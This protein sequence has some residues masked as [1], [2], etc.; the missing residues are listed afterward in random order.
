M[1]HYKTENGGK[2]IVFSS[3]LTSNFNTSTFILAPRWMLPSNVYVSQFRIKSTNS[4][5]IPT[6]LLVRNPQSDMTNVNVDVA[7]LKLALQLCNQGFV[8]KK[9]P[10][11]GS[12]PANSTAA[13]KAINEN[14]MIILQV[15]GVEKGASINLALELTRTLK[16][17]A[18]LSMSEAF[19]NVFV[20]WS[21]GFGK[22]SGF[23]PLS[24]LLS[25]QFLKDKFFLPDSERKRFVEMAVKN[26][27]GETLKFSMQ[28]P[29]RKYQVKAGSTLTLVYDVVARIE[30]VNSAH[31]M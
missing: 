16:Q 25:S 7:A 22:K 2:T 6:F 29:M 26:P 11:S 14:E 1:R 4:P 8:Q 12:K 30:G 24:E 28:G 31:Q 17:Q 3:I 10:I 15:N 23:L 18:K 13:S 9:Q 27:Q 19:R 5:E 20:F 21:S